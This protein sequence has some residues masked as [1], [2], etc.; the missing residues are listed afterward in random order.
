MARKDGKI[1]SADLV[2]VGEGEIVM[3]DQELFWGIGFM[4]VLQFRQW[5]S[6]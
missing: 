3:H 4:V 5:D 6:R 2:S 1:R